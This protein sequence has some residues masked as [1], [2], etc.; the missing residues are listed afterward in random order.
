MEQKGG[1]DTTVNR[2]RD[3]RAR[4]TP[5]SNTSSSSSNTAITNKVPKIF[6]HSSNFILT[7]KMRSQTT[8]RMAAVVQMG[9]AVTTAIHVIKHL[10]PSS[11]TINNNRHNRL[12]HSKQQVVL[13]NKFS[14]CCLVVS[15][16]S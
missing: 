3:S 4:D 16:P 2:E 6:R 15:S 11:S 7:M 12:L 14:S 13:H 1:K 5:A 9:V 8:T 10:S